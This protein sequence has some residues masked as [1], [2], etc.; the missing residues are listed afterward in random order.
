MN[1]L[2]AAIFA[3]LVM[4]CQWVTPAIAQDIA[5]KSHDGG[6]AVSGTL[7]GYDG[8]FYRL[9]TDFGV[10]TLDSSGVTCSGTACPTPGTALAR[11]TLSG[12]GVTGDTLLPALIRGFAETEGYV[13]A[14][15]RTESGERVF[16]LSDRPGG[17]LAIEFTLRTASTG[18]GFLDLIANQAD[19][20]LALREVSDTE[21]AIALDAGLGDLSG[22]RQVRVLARDALVAVVHPEN[23]VRQLSFTALAAVFAG[24]TTNWEALGGAPAPITLHLTNPGHG[25]A[26]LFVERM[27]KA[28]GMP[29][30]STV[31]LHPSVE[32]VADAVAG[33]PSAIG[34]SLLS[35]TD[36]ATV[37]TLRDDCTSGLPARSETVKADDYPLTMPMYLYL[38]GRRL[39]GAAADFLNWL[40]SDAAQE[41]VE[42]A[43]LIAGMT[44]ETKPL[45]VQ[46]DRLAT[47][48]RNAG[49]EVS[50][51]ELQR[52]MVLLSGKERLSLSFRFHG[53]ST[54]LDAASRANIVTLAAALEA[55]RFE[56]RRLTFVGFS[57]GA[58]DA[59]S[60]LRLSRRRAAAVRAAVLAEARELDPSQG[61]I[62]TDGF[63]EALPMACDDTD[64]GKQV[65]RR[66]EI[67]VD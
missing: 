40:H 58:G 26:G 23:P 28:G 65:N 52:M 31:V 15:T 54:D 11:V 60:N 9:A 16:R 33:D 47:A 10:L 53:G 55:G 32:V 30:A 4:S 25:I 42:R 8:A 24:E 56:G 37:L 1:D 35:Q 20:V 48:I 49:P 46:G 17:D 45:S 59:A 7:L 2:C 61:V 5:L 27:L 64:W 19:M 50:L 29:L 3:A 43:G 62:D 39:P 34:I 18:D 6:L 14:D 21:R 57:D 12:T 41:A 66:V 22:P 13:I 67:W 63:G 36:P 38:P 51:A 44:F